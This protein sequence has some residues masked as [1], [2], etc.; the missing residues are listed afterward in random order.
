MKSPKAVLGVVLVVA[1]V[2]MV[3]VLTAGSAVTKSRSPPEFCP[4]AAGSC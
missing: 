2:A 4:A 3:V 1:I